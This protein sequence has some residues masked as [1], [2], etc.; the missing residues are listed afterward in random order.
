[1]KSKASKGLEPGVARRVVE[2]DAGR[3]E[4]AGGRRTGTAG[5]GPAADAAPRMPVD[6]GERGP[7]MVLDEVLEVAV[8][9]TG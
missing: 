3:S 9:E 4:S 2:D 7:R 6:A 8:A 1:M 5:E